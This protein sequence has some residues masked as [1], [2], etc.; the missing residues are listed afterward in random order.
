MSKHTH[1]CFFSCFHHDKREYKYQEMSP[2]WLMKHREIKM[3]SSWRCLHWTGGLLVGPHES[4]QQAFSLMS[5]FL[6]KE[7]KSECCISSG[8]NK[9]PRWRGR[10][11]LYLQSSLY[12]TQRQND[13]I[14]HLIY[15]YK[16]C[17]FL[18]SSQ[19]DHVRPLHINEILMKDRG[20]MRSVFL[21]TTLGTLTGRPGISVLCVCK[22]AQGHTGNL[23][24][25][26]SRHLLEPCHQMSMQR[27]LCTA[28]CLPPLSMRKGHVCRLVTA[29]WCVLFYLFYI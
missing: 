18:W 23:L 25:R 27:F 17:L 26:Q 19:W 28:A 20:R 24:Q 4:P 1:T 29:A 6:D 22:R 10:S 13:E 3:S 11:H 16:V 2:Q 21:L 14:L 12:Q 8:W 7:M 9:S 15:S 5:I